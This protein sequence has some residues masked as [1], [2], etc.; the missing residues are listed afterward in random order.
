MTRSLPSRALESGRAVVLTD[1]EAPEQR[2]DAPQSVFQGEL[3]SVLCV[4]LPGPHGAMGVLY[5]DSRKPVEAFGPTELAVFQTLAVHGASGH[6]ASAA[7]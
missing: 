5:V 1:A 3:R 7:T 4:P 2:K 6:R